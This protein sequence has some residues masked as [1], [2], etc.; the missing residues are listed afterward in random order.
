MEVA[1][2]KYSNFSLAALFVLGLTAVTV[3][4]VYLSQSAISE[5]V[6]DNY[7]IFSEAEVLPID[8]SIAELPQHQ[9]EWIPISFPFHWRNQ[10]PDTRAVWYRISFTAAE[11]EP[12]IDDGDGQNEL[13]LYL[14]RLNQTADFWINGS[15]FG[16]GGSTGNPM[17]RHW[18]SPL[19]FDLAATLIESENTLLVKHFAQHSWGSF[20]SVVIGHADYL[21]EIYN[22]K[23]FLQ[24]DVS[25]GL[26][27]FVIST[28]IFT[29][30]VWIY[31][32]KESEYLWFS[33]ASVGL[34]FYILH[35]FIRYLPINPDIWRWFSNITTDLWAASLLIFVLRS[36]AIEKP[37]L[38]KA[39]Y[40]YLA[41]GVVVYFYASFF[42]AFD[43]N[44]YFH[45]GALLIGIYSFYL[46]AQE[47]FS[48]REPL[49]AFYCSVI[50][51]LFVAGIHDM[52]MQA[53]LNN[54]WLIQEE[55]SFQNHINLLHFAAPI[56]FI[57]IAG[58]LIKQFISSMN[59][60]DRLNIELESRIDSA[61]E[62]LAENYRAIEEV[63][64]KQSALEE[65]ER[66]YRDLHDDVGSKLLSLYYRLDNESDSTLAKSA[67]EDLRDIVSRKS[68]ET[69]ALNVAVEQ[70][71]SEAQDRFQDT[72]TKLNWENGSFPSDV[73]LNEQ[74]QAHLRRMLREVLSNALLHSKSA[75][76]TK[77][78]IKYGEQILK[79]KVANNDNSSPVS[80]WQAG[81]GISNL[82]VRARDL[83]GT[84]NINDLDSQWV[85]VAWEIPLGAN[86]EQHT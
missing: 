2:K 37:L 20:E 3:M 14:W 34:S 36:L 18:N 81:R 82:R 45:A 4:L 47:F 79:I 12:L 52:A 57:F 59:E 62:E 8:T 70:W 74:Q 83:M 26:F 15:K 55:Q 77:V 53:I 65:R 23:Y 49:P 58:S 10:F 73:F 50:S 76:E 54:G 27:V 29:L 39:I 16:S 32:R 67:L 69:C 33:I 85:E 60:A 66:I 75:T 43:L 21:S 84:L 28:G 63:L 86:S 64:V 44:I 42:Q 61:K 78:L 71:K 9:S 19:Y 24:H 48:T 80:E 38:E 11:M 17:A 5:G 25:L 72:N 22:N 40:S 35:Q 1:V 41:T 13:G 56:V 6:S 46:C 51:I 30:S 31:R 68:L 7:L